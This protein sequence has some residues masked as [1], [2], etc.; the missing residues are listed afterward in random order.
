[1]A[2]PLVTNDT[3]GGDEACSPK[4][5][6]RSAVSVTLLVAESYPVADATNVMSPGSNWLS[7]YRPSGVASVNSPEFTPA[8]TSTLARTSAALAGASRTRPLSE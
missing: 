6:V 2:L 1:M 7:T 3:T 4:S 5:V 8:T